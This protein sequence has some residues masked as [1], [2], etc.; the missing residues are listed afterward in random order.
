MQVLEQ[1]CAKKRLSQ[2]LNIFKKCLGNLSSWNNEDWNF[3]IEE[4]KAKLAVGGSTNQL[5]D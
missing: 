1:W 5:V 2:G 3:F 4:K